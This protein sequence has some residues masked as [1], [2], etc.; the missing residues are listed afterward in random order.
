MRILSTVFIVIV[1]LIIGSGIYYFLNRTEATPTVNNA[2]NNAVDNS[3]LGMLDVSVQSTT[4]TEATI[5]WTT[6]KPSTSLVKITDASGAVIKTTPV[7]TLA[8]SHSITI[9]GLRPSTT[10]HYTVVSTD[11]AGNKMTSGGELRTQGTALV[12]ADKTPP[13]ISGLGVSNITE[14]SAI[15]TWLTNE[16]ATGQVKYQKTGEVSSTTPLDTNLTTTH[17]VTLT[18]LDSGTSYNFSIISKDAAGNE[19][20]ADQTFTTLTPIPVGTQVGNRAPDFTLQ[21]LNGK[22]VKLSDFRGKIVMIN[23]WAVW[24]EPC[25]QELPYMQAISDNWSGKGVVVLAIAVNTSER[26]DIVGQYIEQNPYTFHVLWDAKGQAESLY[27]VSILP[28]TFFIDAEGII[29]KPPQIGSFEDQ[30]TI[31]NILSSLK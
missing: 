16:P 11:A 14:A 8:S 23:F 28:T 6:D 1:C 19:A 18:K 4:E 9:S 20:T 27:S 21:D 2:V 30:E 25:K 3:L 24:C 22:D 17:T 26:L 13:T 15:I 31:E 10:Y 7:E 29:K 12:T 5:K